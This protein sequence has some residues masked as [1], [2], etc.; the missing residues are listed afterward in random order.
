MVTVIHKNV[1]DFGCEMKTVSLT[2]GS[3]AGAI[4]Q[5][6]LV[7]DSLPIFS[8]RLARVF[9]RLIFRLAESHCRVL[10][11]ERSCFVPN[12]VPQATQA[13]A[14]ARSMWDLHLGMVA[15]SESVSE[16]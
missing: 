9:A 7:F 4:G 10:F 3:G 11:R 14:P 2:N 5:A 16:K 1:F 13:G 12:S 6:A 15:A 8:S